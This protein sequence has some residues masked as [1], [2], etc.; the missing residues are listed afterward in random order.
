MDTCIARAR[1]FLFRLSVNP[2]AQLGA[3]GVRSPARTCEDRTLRRAPRWHRGKPIMRRAGASG[4]PPADAPQTSGLRHPSDANAKRRPRSLRPRPP[5]GKR[6]RAIPPQL[7]V[8]S[9]GSP[10]LTEFLQNLNTNFCCCTLFLPCLLLELC[11]RGASPITSSNVGIRR[12]S[13]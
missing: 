2:D 11:V 8:F 1:A 3:P 10:E 9:I 12:I 7:G 5:S 6:Q 13:P 4:T